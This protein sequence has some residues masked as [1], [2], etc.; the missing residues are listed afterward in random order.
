MG[1]LFRRDSRKTL[2]KFHNTSELII[3]D[4]FDSNLEVRVVV[5]SVFQERKKGQD[6]TVGISRRS[7]KALSTK[8]QLEKIKKVAGT[9]YFNPPRYSFDLMIIYNRKL[10]LEQFIQAA[11]NKF[12]YISHLKNLGIF[13]TVAMQGSKLVTLEL[14]CI[15][16]NISK[17]TLMFDLKD[18]ASRL[19]VKF[20]ERN[21][22]TEMIDK[23]TFF[24]LIKRR[25]VGNI[26]CGDI[27][28]DLTNAPE[29]K[30]ALEAFQSNSWKPDEQKQ[31]TF[32]YFTEQDLE[33][34]MRH[35]GVIDLFFTDE[36]VV[37]CFD[38]LDI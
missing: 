36:E 5:P 31:I 26:E 19:K 6:L 7:P 9:T 11:F 37:R 4:N 24:A 28:F 8:K 34:F 13:H 21:Q 29:Y 38:L 22:M 10:N 30:V 14:F 32:T 35:N 15:L 17:D 23:E 2:V 18:L 25:V 27:P 12:N 16:Q 20:I 33:G 3:I 1:K